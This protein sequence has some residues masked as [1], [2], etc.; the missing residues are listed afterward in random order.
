MIRSMT[1]FG[2][3][4]KEDERRT[5]VVEIRALNRRYLEILVRLRR[6]DGRLGDMQRSD[7]REGRLF[8]GNRP[9]FT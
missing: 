8:L 7:G 9:A 3:A 2:M 4:E 5:Y 1:A 6:G